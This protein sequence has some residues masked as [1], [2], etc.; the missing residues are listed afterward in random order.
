MSARPNFYRPVQYVVVNNGARGIARY[1][2]APRMAKNWVELH[3]LRTAIFTS[4]KEASKACRR[5]C[6]GQRSP[7]DFQVVEVQ[8][9]RV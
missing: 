9:C 5:A 1:L 6:K 7:A 8:L 2:A 3:P 4:K